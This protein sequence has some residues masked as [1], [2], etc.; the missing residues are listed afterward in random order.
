MSSHDCVK[1]EIAMIM[2]SKK[3]TKNYKKTTLLTNVIEKI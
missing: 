2:F 1:N 3:K